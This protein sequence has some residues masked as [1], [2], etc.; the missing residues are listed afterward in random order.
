M[1]TRSYPYLMLLTALLF[2]NIACSTTTAREHPMITQQLELIDTVV[3][4]PPV[5]SITNVVFTGENE[6]LERL[7]NQISNLLVVA[8]KSRL[9]GQGYEIIDFDFESACAEN[10][11]LSFAI[12]QA[13]DGFD[14]AK[15]TLYKKVAI[16]ES[17]KRKFKASVGTATNL[18][19]SM[20]GADAVVLIHYMGFKK[21]GGVVAKDVAVGV[22]LAA[23]TGTYAQP[24]TEGAYVEVAVIDGATGDVIWADLKSNNKLSSEIINTAMVSLPM[25]M[26][27]PEPPASVISEEASD[28]QPID[29]LSNEA[30]VSET[31]A[32]EMGNES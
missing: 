2:S 11:D 30:P 5:V 8:A 32:P 4:P 7:E 23:L 24:P 15:E 16:P 22:V 6:Q 12:K 21:S 1:P 9:E 17:D 28:P 26:D 27:P 14:K 13:R 18:I 20:S 3:I 19:A 31:A 25:D 10:P 29:G